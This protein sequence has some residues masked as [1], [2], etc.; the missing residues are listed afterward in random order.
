MTILA[1]YSYPF[2][3]EHI[4]AYDGFFALFNYPCERKSYVSFGVVQLSMCEE[5]VC[6]FFYHALFYND[7]QHMFCR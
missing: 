6:A 7:D 4:C 1:L 5:L 3:E 2:M